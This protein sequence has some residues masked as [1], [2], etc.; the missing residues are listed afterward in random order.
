VV[1]D[2]GPSRSPFSLVPRGTCRRR[3]AARSR[4]GVRRSRRG[5]RGGDRLLAPLPSRSGIGHLRKGLLIPPG[6]EPETSS[7]RPARGLR[8]AARLEA[9][10][11][12]QQQHRWLGFPLAVRQKYA[13]DRGGTL[14]AA[15]TFYGFFSLFP[16]LLVF[17]S[18]LGF[19][20]Q[21]HQHLQHTIVQS[22]LGRFPVIGPDLEIQSI[23]GNAL[24]L[25]LGIAGAVWAGLGVVLAAQDAMNQ[26]W[27]VPLYRRPNFLQARL[28]AL[29]LLLVLGGG[30]IA[31]TA[32]GGLGTVGVGFAL[33]WKL[34]AIAL[35]TALNFALFWLAFQ[36]LTLHEVPW[37]SL[38]GGALAAA[39]ASTGLQLLGGY[40]VGHVLKGATNTYGTFALV[41][42]LLSWIALTVQVMLY[43]A[44]GNV[45][46]SKRLWPRSVFQAG[47]RS[48]T[49]ADAEALRRHVLTE[50]SRDDETITVEF[51]ADDE[52]GRGRKIDD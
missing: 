52:P 5:P 38:R 15:I 14:A 9:F 13:D 31:S 46:A 16:L 35:S 39:L 42:G 47:A 19:V 25:G 7:P 50:Q 32:V 45:V 33:G 44:E 10:D 30:V 29:L 1:T 21:G 49:E 12:Y 23:K 18:V 20:L 22:A 36:L 17:V 4:E 6:P 26:L 27:G 11:R 51:G 34:G 41:I 28:R 3:G 43:A 40:Y 24:A 8:A 48:P 37:R 2:A